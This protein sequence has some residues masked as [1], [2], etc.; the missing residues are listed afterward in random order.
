MGLEF[1]VTWDY[2]CPF[3]RNAH[4]H[5][6]VGLAAGADWQVRFVPFSLGQVHVTDGAPDVWD[7]PEQGTGIAALQVGVTV[8]D[9]YPERFPAAHR[10]L[11]AARH[12]EGEHIEDHSVLRSVLA[13]NGVDPDDVLASIE[14]AS[15]LHRS[16]RLGSSTNPS[17]SP[18]ACGA[19]Q[20][21]SSGTKRCSS[22]SCNDPQA[23][24]PLSR[25]GPLSRP[26]IY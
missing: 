10:A 25:S 2:R 11:F 1:V 26:S 24:M 18:T 19:C 14:D 8:R 5:I 3:A 21:S 7:R 12:D 6:L 23:L 20:H 13:A 4:E 22:D 15:A 16:I 17:V 9:R